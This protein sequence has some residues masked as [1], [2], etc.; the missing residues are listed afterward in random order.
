MTSPSSSSSSSSSL[1]Y[2]SV[3][4]I[5]DQTKANFVRC[6]VKIRQKQHAPEM[7]MI[8]VILSAQ[9]V[10]K[11]NVTNCYNKFTTIGDNSFKVVNSSHQDAED[12]VLERDNELLL[13]KGELESVKAGLVE[14]LRVSE[15]KHVAFEKLRAADKDAA[16]E[17]RVADK[18]A[19][20]KL[21]EADKDAAEEALAAMKLTFDELRAA[22]KLTF[23]ELRSELS[24]MKLAWDKSREA[25]RLAIENKKAA[26]ML[27]IT[28][29]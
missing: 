15:E 1:S 3:P 28:S 11:H 9:E 21:R 12:I 26:L 2:F 16:E 6:C 22:D 5:D 20:E 10:V 24:A 17:L 8:G 29:L 18:D 7:D 19:A 27:I 25:D 14:M 13:L 4:Y 23:D